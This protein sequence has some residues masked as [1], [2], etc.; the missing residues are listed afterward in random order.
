MEGDNHTIHQDVINRCL[1]GD[2]SAQYQLYKLY[3]KAMLNVSYRIVANVGDAEDVLQESFISAFKN[4]RSFKGDSSFGAWLKRIV[5]NKSLNT[6]KKKS[7]EVT[8]SDVIPDLI[9]E[10]ENIDFSDR[11]LEVELIKKAVSKLPEGYRAVFSLYLFE[12]YDHL[13]ISEILGISESTS[14]SQYNR[15]KKKL[16]ELIKMELT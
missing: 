16:R 10:S 12:G 1:E 9:D 11:Y 6:L 2:R 3:S 5:I 13:E 14:K 15:S 4:L 7:I 8:T